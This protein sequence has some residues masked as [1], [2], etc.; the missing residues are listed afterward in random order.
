M[1]YA[2]LNSVCTIIVVYNQNMYIIIK[3][4]SIFNEKESCF[5]L[6]KTAT[7]QEQKHTI[8]TE[9]LRLI[10]NTKNAG[11]TIIDVT[12]TVNID[13]NGTPK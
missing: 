3:T 6:I 5:P 1:I 10:N 8:G 11:I 4:D 7:A 13:K 12:C 9:I 2:K